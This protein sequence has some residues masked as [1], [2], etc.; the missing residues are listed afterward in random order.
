[1]LAAEKMAIFS[2]FLSKSS[3]LLD[4]VPISL[5]FPTGQRRAWV[6]LK[7]VTSLAERHGLQRSYDGRGQW[8]EEE[9][10]Q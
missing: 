8:W 4:K 9:A 3:F 1:M 7:Q 5:S 10:S 2:Y 6:A